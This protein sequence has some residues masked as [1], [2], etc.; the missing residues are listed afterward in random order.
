[1]VTY[2]TDEN[3]VSNDFIATLTVVTQYLLSRFMKDEDRR[4]VSD[5][6]EDWREVS[7]ID[8]DRRE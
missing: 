2:Y 8:E 7:Y 3:D 1:N 4:E 5:I 6:D